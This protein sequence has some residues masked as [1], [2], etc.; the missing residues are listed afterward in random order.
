M[1]H[2]DTNSDLD[3]VIPNL[4][5]AIPNHVKRIV[6]IYDSYGLK[7]LI[8]EPTRETIHTSTLIDH[9]AVSNANNIVESGAIKTAV[10]DNYLPYAIRKFQDGSKRQHKVNKIRQMKHFDENAFLQGLALIEWITHLR[11]SADISTIVN[12]ITSLISRVIQKYA[13]LVE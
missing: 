12:I 10:N 9:I 6:N 1:L 2:R 3:H 7:Q 13:P 5:H 8:T 4:D 11:S